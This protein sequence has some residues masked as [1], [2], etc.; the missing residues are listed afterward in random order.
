M[1]RKKETLGAMLAKLLSGDK[2]V[3]REDFEKSTVKFFADNNIH[4]VITKLPQ[5]SDKD[6]TK[7]RQQILMNKKTVRNK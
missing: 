1:Y 5:E 6:Q 3:T 7:I 2:S 4:C